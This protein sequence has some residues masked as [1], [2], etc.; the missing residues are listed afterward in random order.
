MDSLSKYKFYR[1][2]HCSYAERLVI[3]S[4]RI[5][6]QI[7]WAA[8]FKIS[9]MKV[10]I[11]RAIKIYCERNF[12][13][14]EQLQILSQ[15]QLQICWVFSKSVANKKA[16]SL[17]NYKKSVINEIADSLSNYKFY[18][19]CNCRFAEYLQSLSPKK[20]RFAD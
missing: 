10:Q 15:M 19:K 14:A 18:R 11:C 8:F 7:R 9:R 1:K 2:C 6:L 16:D 13:C 3:L 20:C 17:S 4:R 12:K 5:K